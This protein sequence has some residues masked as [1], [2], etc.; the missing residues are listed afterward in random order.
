MT[1]KTDTQVVIAGRVLHLSG[2]E[3]AEYQQR[4]ASYIN[5]MMAEYAK[6]QSYQN[7]PEDMKAILLEINIADDY[8]KAKKQIDL[9]NQELDDKEKEIYDLKHDLV[10]AQMRLE[11]MT[12]QVADLQKNLAEN[13]K[14]IVQL[15]TQL[16]GK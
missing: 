14:K 8:F 2:Y 13:A 9:L 15:E 1:D 12:Q 3:T 4:I 5:D 6:I 11:T 16:K 7:Q 10:A